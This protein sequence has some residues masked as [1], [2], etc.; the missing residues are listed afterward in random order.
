MIQ[1]ILKKNC[2]LPQHQFIRRKSRRPANELTLRY[3]FGGEDALK[4]EKQC[5][6]GSTRHKISVSNESTKR[7]SKNDNILVHLKKNFKQTFAAN[8]NTLV[9]LFCI[10]DNFVTQQQQHNTVYTCDASDAQHQCCYMILSKFKGYIRSYE[11]IS[12]LSVH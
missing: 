3:F 2:G 9:V 8:Q 4:K 1:Y 5:N 6:H 12:T 7:E 11:I 10:F